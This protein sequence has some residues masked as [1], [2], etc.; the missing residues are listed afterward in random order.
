MLLNFSIKHKCFKLSLDLFTAD[1][2]ASIQKVQMEMSSSINQPYG[3]RK[4]HN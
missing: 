1:K 4:V 3:E 2:K